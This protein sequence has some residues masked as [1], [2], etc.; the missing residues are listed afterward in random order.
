MDRA[1]AHYLH[2]AGA[3]IATA[4]IAA[5]DHAF[6][7]IERYPASGSPRYGEVCDAHGVRS[8]LLS[9][10]PYVIMYIE[11]DTYL[12]II[13]VLHQHADIPSHLLAEDQQP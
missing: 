11:H 13:R 8:W 9:N 12:D 2:E 4:F 5:M 10:F 3:P 1:F 7:H 6:Q